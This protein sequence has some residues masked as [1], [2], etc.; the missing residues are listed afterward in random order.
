MYK[1]FKCITHCLSHFGVDQEVY[2]K[3]NI[4]FHCYC[5]TSGS[6][7]RNCMTPVGE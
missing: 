2:A 6:R 1:H 3:A 4:S 7:A 5:T